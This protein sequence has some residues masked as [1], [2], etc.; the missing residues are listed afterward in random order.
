[1]SIGRALIVSA[2]VERRERWLEDLQSSDWQVHCVAS[3]DESLLAIP[4]FLPVLMLLDVLA[5]EQASDIDEQF[6]QRCRDSG[7][8]VIVIFAKPT[9]EDIA[10]SFRRGAIDVLI[11]P[12]DREE[13]FRAIARAGDF[14]DLY[15]QNLGFRGQLERANKELQESLNILRM[16]QMAGRQVQL[17]LLPPGPI[18]QGEYSV[19]HH[20]VPS[21]FLSGDF[22]GYSVA[23]DRF[24]LFY[25]A[26]VSGHG[27]SSAFVTIM[28]SYIIR[29]IIR[30]HI[31]E[32]DPRALLNA[33]EGLIEHVNRQIMALNLDKHLTVFAGSIDT[34]R[35]LLRYVIGAQL[36][37]PILITKDNVEFLPG[38]GKPVG[39]FEDAVWPIEEI[40]LPDN[41]TLA[42]V[43]DGLLDCVE[44]GSMMERE[45]AILA[46]CGRVGVEG[47]HDVLCRELGID[48]I[49]KAQDDVSI[50]MVSRHHE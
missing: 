38:K 29:Q 47:G 37:L 39:L 9:P 6:A 49:D 12:F 35:H 11:E 31:S 13:L 26:D 25:V 23:F 46:A 16:D 40:Q 34:E 28:L 4:D 43:S 21:L 27:A 32:G 41:F 19:S 33:P 48:K 30:R 17:S 10:V 44:G 14:K 5:E 45:Q 7:L 1:M 8:A 42:V 15:Q 50:M 3:R 24:I 2:N 18:T 20:I 22:V 36:P